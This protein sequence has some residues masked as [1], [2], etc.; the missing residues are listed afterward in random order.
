MSDST[1]PEAAAI[2][3]AYEDQVRALFKILVSNLVDEAVSQ[4]ND[5]QCVDKFTAGL[6]IARRP[7]ELALSWRFLRS[8]RTQLDKEARK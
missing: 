7:R 2:E 4:E 3:M 8:W 5:Q 1:S 6:K